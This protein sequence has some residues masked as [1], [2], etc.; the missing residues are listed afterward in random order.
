V[1]I[2]SAR[3]DGGMDLDAGGFRDWLMRPS[4]IFPRG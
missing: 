3:P 1:E 2:L 4:G